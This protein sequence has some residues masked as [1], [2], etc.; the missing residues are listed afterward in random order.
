VRVLPA[1]LKGVVNLARVS[2]STAETS[3]RNNHSRDPVAVQK[4]DQR[5]PGKSRWPRE[6]VPDKPT[7]I[8]PGKPETNVGTKVTTRIECAPMLR[9]RVPAGDGNFCTVTYGPGSRVVVTAHGPYPL[10]VTVRVTAPAIR[11]YRAYQEARE[12]IVRG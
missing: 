9:V 10:A 4:G 2:T 1:A 3:T 6:I 8:V 5:I 11:G 7:P 12:Y